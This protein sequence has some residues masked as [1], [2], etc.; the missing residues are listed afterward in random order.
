[1][2][3]QISFCLAAA[4]WLIFIHN[5]YFQEKKDLIIFSV[6][7]L[8][9]L[10]L[11]FLEKRSNW[12]TFL[13]YCILLII[14]ESFTLHKTHHRKAFQVDQTVYH[15]I[16]MIMNGGLLFL[17]VYSFLALLYYLIMWYAPLS[18]EHISLVPLTLVTLLLISFFLKKRYDFR[19]LSLIELHDSEMLMMSS[20]SSSLILMT[21]FIVHVINNKGIHAVIA[22]II[23]D[24]CMVSLIVMM[25]Q[26]IMTERKVTQYQIEHRQSSM[27]QSAFIAA[28]SESRFL[29]D[30]KHDLVY[31]QSLDPSYNKSLQVV[32]D[33][34][35]HH[36]IPEDAGTLLMNTLIEEMKK[37]TD[38]PLSVVVT[39][40]ASI[41]IKQYNVI[42]NF[43]HKLLEE[44]KMMQIRIDHVDS[45]NRFTFITKCDHNIH[46][47]D[48]PH[49]YVYVNT[50][51]QFVKVTLLVQ[52]T[53]YDE[54]L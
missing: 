45:Y 32:I 13:F 3:F 46:F 14:I 40:A 43:Y 19:S 33:S 27:L 37:A 10:Y 5:F 51:D 31:L 6:V 2:T 47:E 20:L 12:Y 36:Q 4:I 15:E 30:L 1:M 16:F 23:I 17:G 28:K 50:F 52:E 7:E 11:F 25:I 8:G 29:K 18:F 54:S 22:M 44:T 21:S 42:L 24:V 41:N 35:D 48:T 26:F 38:D 39:K 9:L 34:I 53:H 49:Y